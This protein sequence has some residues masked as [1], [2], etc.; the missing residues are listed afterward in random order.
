VSGD[1]LMIDNGKI[2]ANPALAHYGAASMYLRGGTDPGDIKVTAKSKGLK[3]AS[4]SLKTVS[5]ES[6]E[7]AIHAKPIYDYPIIKIDI[8]GEKQLVQFGWLEWTG[9]SNSDLKFNVEGLG[10]EIQV[11]TKNDVNWMANT[12][13][14]GD[15]SFVGTDGIYVE[16]GKINLK[17]SGL[18]KG[19]YMIE[20]YHHSRRPDIKMTNEIEVKLT[21]AKGTFS[22]KSD[23]HIVD[24]YIQDNVGERKPLSIKNKF[25]IRWH[26]TCNIRIR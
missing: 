13:M 16:D 14:L 25:R 7:I 20:T 11:N 10:C 18:K 22:R 17:M 26:Y 15:L 23:D 21:D 1:G 4:I 9:S 3:S 19:K 12:G 8:G 2:D 5:F 6:D 24:Y